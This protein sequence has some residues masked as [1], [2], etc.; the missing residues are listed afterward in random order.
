MEK[1][2][3]D[4][5]DLLLKGNMP[6]K[7][8][9]NVVYLLVEIRKLLEI[10]NKR[11]YN[12]L[13]FYCDWC[14]HIRKD[15]NTDIIKSQIEGIYKEIKEEDRIKELGC[16]VLSRKYSLNFSSMDDLKKEIE[17]FFVEYNI[18]VE[19]I[20]N[21]NWPIFVNTLVTVLADQEIKNPCNGIKYFKFLPKLEDGFI[22]WITS[23]EVKEAE[24]RDYEFKNPFKKF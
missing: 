4:K 10:G 22:K 14:L 1:D 24:Y 8:E 18:S 13:K 12:L 6:L 23:Y 7:E 15:R 11:N 3:V 21:D 20:N 9:A 19:L 5:I 17:Q 16:G 2:I